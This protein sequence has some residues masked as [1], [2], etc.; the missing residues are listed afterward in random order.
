MQI[1]V[2]ISYYPLKEAYGSEVLDFIAALRKGSGV[3]IKTNNL[4]TQLRG[5][6]E[7]TMKCIH[8]ALEV[9]LSKDFKAGVVIKIFN[10]GLELDWLDLPG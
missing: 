8:D 4:S 2:E 5:E 3:E 7:E 6:F 1:T 10:D 9:G